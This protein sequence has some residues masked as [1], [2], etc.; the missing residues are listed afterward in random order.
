MDFVYKKVLLARLP[1]STGRYAV[2]VSFS[3]RLKCPGTGIRQL[4]DEQSDLCRSGALC[5]ALVGQH[6]HRHSDKYTNRYC[7]SF[8]NGDRDLDRYFHGYANAYG[9]SKRHTHRN[10]NL[11][12]HEYANRDS[13]RHSDKYATFANDRSERSAARQYCESKGWI[14]VP[15]YQY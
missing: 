6:D 3:D 8:T 5:A 1:R 9:Y 2:L 15:I 12:T 10:I 14:S 13:K 11:Y 7:H 4:S